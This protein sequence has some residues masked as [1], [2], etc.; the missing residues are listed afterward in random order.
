[1]SERYIQRAAAEG[2][3]SLLGPFQSGLDAF[4]LR[5]LGFGIRGFS[6]SGSWGSRAKGLGSGG[7]R[8]RVG[9]FNVKGLGFEGFRF[10]AVAV[11]S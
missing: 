11:W 1:M 7:F 8:L 2:S 9:G 3:Q 6:V 4:L 10:R 5:G